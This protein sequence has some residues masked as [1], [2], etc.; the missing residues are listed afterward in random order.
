M[1]FFLIPSWFGYLDLF[2]PLPPSFKVEIRV[3]STPIDLFPD[4]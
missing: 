2:D 1:G 3:I 4:R